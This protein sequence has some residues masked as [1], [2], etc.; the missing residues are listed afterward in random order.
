MTNICVIGAGHVG[1]LTT[2]G[3]SKLRHRVSCPRI[4]GKSHSLEPGWASPATE[5]VLAY[6]AM[7][8]ASRPIGTKSKTICCTRE[9]ELLPGS[10]LTY[11]PFLPNTE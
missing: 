3:F 9:G 4:D 1:L 11:T 2:A 10:Y 7:G 6:G 5:Q 8:T